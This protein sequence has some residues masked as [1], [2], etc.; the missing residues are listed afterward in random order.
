MHPGLQ[1]R[2][3]HH[4]GEFEQTVVDVTDLLAKLDDGQKKKVQNHLRKEPDLGMKIAEAI[5]NEAAIAGVSNQRRLQLRSMMMQASFRLKNTSPGVVIDEYVDKARR[6]GA[7]SGQQTE[8]ALRLAGRA[9]S[10]SFWQHHAAGL[11]AQAGPNAVAPPAGGG[12]GGA[13]SQTLWTPP[14]RRRAT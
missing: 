5:D 8:M 2:M 11:G 12:G 13:A 10:D 1:D 7:E 6:L 9:G 4:K 14:S 3:R